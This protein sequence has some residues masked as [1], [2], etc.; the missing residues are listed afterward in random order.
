[1]HSQFGCELAIQAVLMAV[2]Q[3]PT[4]EKVVLHSDRGVQYTAAGFQAF[5][6]T[7]GIVS[8][9]SGVGNCYDNDVAERFF[10]VLKRER[11]YRRHYPTPAEARKNILNYSERFYNRQRR[12]SC[13]QGL[14]PGN[15]ANTEVTNS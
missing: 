12:H 2:W 11:V 4:S 8:S 15:Y 3:T 9:M 13:S 1:M 5:L 7:L 6:N 14:P 10:G